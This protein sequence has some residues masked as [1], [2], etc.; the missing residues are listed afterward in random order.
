MKSKIIR[1]LSII[2]VESKERQP[3]FYLLFQAFFIGTFN[4]FLYIYAHAGFLKS[5][6]VDKLPEALVMSGAVSLFVVL[7]YQIFIS[8]F[9]FKTAKTIFSIIIGIAIIGLLTINYFIPVSHYG[10]FLFTAIFP[11][12]IISLQKFNST[13][14]HYFPG[15]QSVRFSRTL[16]NSR[17]LGFVFMGFLLPLILFTSVDMDTMLYIGLSSYIAHLI[18]EFLFI[19]S[20][21]S[22]VQESPKKHFR[23]LNTLSN[24]FVRQLTWFLLLSYMIGFLIHYAF[25]VIT[26][27]NFQSSVGLI[28]FFGIF[29]STMIVFSFFADKYLLNRILNNLGLPY[30]IVLSPLFIGIFIVMASLI[31]LKSGFNNAVSGYTFV[32]LF[33]AAGKYIEHLFKFSVETPSSN[34]LLTSVKSLDIDSVKLFVQGPVVASALL[35]SGLIVFLQSIYLKFNLLYLALFIVVLS[36]LWFLSAVKLIKRYRNNLKLRYAEIDQEKNVKE[37]LS[38]PVKYENLIFSNFKENNDKT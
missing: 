32:F 2:N 22:L 8:N 14:N 17:E 35:F 29:M 19:R 27:D 9:T 37:Y 18:F 10:F 28:K 12:Q 6:D 36:V 11:I 21:N 4:G 1:L 16:H 26:N 33:F 15:K 31:G 30:S 23:F 20:G 25:I 7:L 3:V 38:L 24:K 13:L 5:E 34:I